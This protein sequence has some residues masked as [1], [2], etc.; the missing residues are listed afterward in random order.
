ME[1]ELRNTTPKEVQVIEVEEAEEKLNNPE[2]N[3]V[4]ADVRDKDTF[5]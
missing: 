5:D 4:L 3:A 1:Q 2:L